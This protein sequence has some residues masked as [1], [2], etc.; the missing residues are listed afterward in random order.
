MQA[1]WMAGMSTSLRREV[2]TR[3]LAD[4]PQKAMLLRADIHS[5][6]DD[7]QWGIWVCLRHFLV[8]F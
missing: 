4:R 7:Y 5:L 1:I 3:Q 2:N 6:F 8:H